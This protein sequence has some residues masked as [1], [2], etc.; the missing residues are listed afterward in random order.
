MQ[1]LIQLA[2]SAPLRRLLRGAWLA[3][4]LVGLSCALSAQPHAGPG[5]ERTPG[6]LGIEFKD[7][8]DADAATLHVPKRG[9][10]IVMVDHDGPAGKAGL[11]AHDIVVQLNGL[12]VEGG[13]ALKRMIHDAGAGANVAL[14]VLR[15]GR[16]LTLTAQLCDQQEL[17]RQAFQEHTG[18]AASGVPNADQA[19]VVQGFVESYTVEPAVPA[20]ASTQSFI[21]SV[22][23][24]EPYTGLMLAGM[25][26]QLASFFGAPQGKGLLVHSVEANSPAAMAGLKAG[27]VV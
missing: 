25:E 16:P 2:G 12:A 14:A 21:G 22:L 19:P 1:E 27:D 17:A 11:R 6:Y 4:A 15:D 8:T 13:A 7:L 18:V 9:V 20:K 26:P 24:L 10:E 5:H 3:S 23:H